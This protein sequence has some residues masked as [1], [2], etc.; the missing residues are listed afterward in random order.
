MFSKPLFKQ[1]IKAN[2]LSWVVVTVATCFMLAMILAVVGSDSINSIISTQSGFFV[3]DAVE[4]QIESASMSYY[5]LTASSL[6]GYDGQIEGVKQN[7]PQLAGG[8]NLIISGYPNP[9]YGDKLAVINMIAG[10]PLL[11]ADEK[12]FAEAFL[13]I[14]A[15]NTDPSLT[16]EKTGGQILIN[17]IANALYNNIL[18]NGNQEEAEAIKQF[19]LNVLSGYAEQSVQ[20]SQEFATDAVTAKIKDLMAGEL[21]EYGFTAEE[22]AETAKDAIISLRA[23]IS[24]RYPGQALSQLNPADVNELIGK[25]SAGVMDSFPENVKEGLADMQNLDI[26]ELMTGSIFYKIAGLLLPVIYIIMVA[27]SLIAG[28]VDSGSMAYVLSTPTKRNAVTIT[29]MCFL[30]VSLLAMCLLTTATGMITLFIIGGSSITYK[31]MLLLNA[32]WFF[33][34]LAFSGICFFASAWFN[35]S[36]HSMAAGGGVSMYFLVSTILG[37]FG[38]SEMPSIVRMDSM[39]VFN[40]TSIIYLFDTESILGGTTAF[41]WKL[42][43]LAGIGLLGYIGGILRF[44]KK[45]LPL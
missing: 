41:I 5:Y 45:D 4:S 29:Q 2:F 43:V 42:A 44:N 22:I 12:I 27:N 31:E 13:N 24:V 38:S 14:Y 7:A 10:N 8:Y 19:I 17:S 39:N 9:T 16:P 15:F 36:K 1:S 26:A 37:L 25:L 32:G 11:S 6:E 23:Q 21:A 34:V 20:T 3:K 40:Y 18:E 35:R 30:V 28:Q 33:A